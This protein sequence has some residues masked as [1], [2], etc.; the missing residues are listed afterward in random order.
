MKK[1]VR[2]NTELYRQVLLFSSVPISFILTFLRYA[3]KVE[4][5]LVDWMIL[6]AYTFSIFFIGWR[7]YIKQMEA[8]QAELKRLITHE[9]H[10]NKSLLLIN[11]EE[12]L[13]N[14]VSL[15]IERCADLKQQAAM[16]FFDIDELGEINKKF[17]FDVGDEV[18]VDIIKATQSLIEPKDHL[19]RVKGDA[20]AV[21]FP[22]KGK[23]HAY[24]FAY[25]LSEH[26]KQ[27]E[28]K[29][30]LPVTCRFVTMTLDGW[31]SDDRV[32][33]LAYEQLKIAKQLGRGVII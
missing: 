19:G 31:N 14:V 21:V 1:S 6:L 23:E 3:L 12:K 11:T 7:A 32:L 2:Q 24:D 8:N 10:I 33:A 18:I 20:F 15:E 22:K 30:G 9:K 29:M 4:H 26:V 5:F 16:V 25:K 27:I 17:G 13:K 28:V